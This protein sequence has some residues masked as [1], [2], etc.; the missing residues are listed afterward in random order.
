MWI[1]ARWCILR[2]TTGDNSPTSLRTRGSFLPLSL[3]LDDQPTADR[4]RS[5][6]WLTVAGVLSAGTVALC[7]LLVWRP[8]LGLT[9]TW[10]VAALALPLVFLLAPSA[11]RNSCPLA[12]ANQLPRLAGFA[13]EWRL[14]PWLA[15]QAFAVAAV[16]FVVLVV[17]RRLLLDRS[18]PATA[19]VIAGGL[20]LAFAGGMA[21][22]GKA[23]WC[24]TLCPLFAAQRIY[25]RSPVVRVAHAHCR[26]CVGCVR[27]CSDIDPAGTVTYEDSRTGDAAVR[28]LLV[29][30]APGL[31]LG[32]FAVPSLAGVP[33][34]GTVAAVVL[35]AL[36]SMGGYVLLV[37]LLG[38]GSGRRRHLVSSA[39][40][41][42]AFGLFYVF[43][44]PR[45]LDVVG[46][47]H[48][49][50]EAVV[51][52]LAA[53]GAVG[54]WRR[55]RRAVTPD[56]EDAPTG[57]RPLIPLTLAPRAG[58]A[59]PT[60]TPTAPATAAATVPAA[61]VRKAVVRFVGADGTRHPVAIPSGATLADAA[62]A[63]D[64][65]V[66]RGCGAGSCGADPVT[67]LSGRQHLSAPTREEQATLRRLNVPTGTR[68]ACVACVTGEVTVTTRPPATTPVGGIDPRVRSVVVVGNGIAGLTA[69]DWVRRLHPACEVHL[70]GREPHHT[71]NRMALT[72]IVTGHAELTKLGLLPPEWF[73]EHRITAHVGAAVRAI[74]LEAREVA[75]AGGERL[76]F[77]RL[78][79]A[80]G[81]APADQAIDG[82]PL[83]G[84][85]VLRTAEQALAVRAHTASHPDPKAA[86]VVGAGPLGIE[87]AAA[88]T[89]LGLDV[90]LVDRHRW[91]AHRLV[92]SH[93]GRLVET[94]LTRLGVHVHTAA[95]VRWAG[96]LRRVSS[97]RLG[98]GRRIPC[99][100]L[101]LC[102]GTRPDVDLARA[103]GLYVRSGVVV[104]HTLRTS[105]PNVFAVGDV[106]EHPAGVSGLWYAAVEQAEVAAEQA[107]ARDSVLARRY[108]PGPPVTRIGLPDLE[109]VS[110]GRTRAVD[111][112]HQ[113]A[114]V[115]DPVRGTYLKVVV[116]GTGAVAGGVVVN[117]PAAATT[118]ESLANSGADMRP[119]I[120]RVRVGDLDGLADPP[121][122]AR[123]A[124]L[125]ERFR[126]LTRV[127]TGHAGRV[128]QDLAGTATGAAADGLAAWRTNVKS[129]LTFAAGAT[130]RRD[131]RPPSRPGTFGPDVRL[132][133]DDR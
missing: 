2:G 4:R 114:I 44:A 117:D 82:L 1:K 28:Q 59:T 86:V 26:T 17:L 35:P 115:D 93:V 53:A 107:V 11:W 127:G 130:V 67:V 34:V 69:A 38:A 29:G 75:L 110:I 103:A 122:D 101:L 77:D 92:D 118:L 123:L 112:D 13:R 40:A 66:P 72:D 36:A 19:A 128:V 80:T 84:A 12:L 43:A 96:G 45:A 41:A 54:W 131:G 24:G 100:L 129:A 52:V 124:L 111:S 7:V 20:V 121:T 88:L 57:A 64:V 125:A 3:T 109:I 81:A 74:D 39:F 68:L 76:P 71:Y 49:V 126:R 48:P 55:D 47:N 108:W 132:E 9:L 5:A 105:D 113:V 15:R 94:A 95:T 58:T 63:A 37:A 21:V 73:A 50:A 62:R 30:A 27:P 91:P 23:G 78:V 87:V 31:V 16:T 98:N 120:A 90:H 116:S 6:S 51:G 89:A 14:P 33:V 83:P 25:G 18:G 60:P 56:E 42:S 119:H 133:E 70:I 85:H 65:T 99:D 32:Y 79:L 10:N 46:W 61:G 102:T 97:V 8:A 22:Q 106:A 104:D